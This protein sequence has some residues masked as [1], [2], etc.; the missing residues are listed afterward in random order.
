MH[1]SQNSTSAAILRKR[2]R[3]PRNLRQSYFFARSESCAKVHFGIGVP[4]K[5]GATVTRPLNK[6]SGFFYVPCCAGSM[7]PFLAGRV[8]ASK[9]APVPDSGTPTLHGL[10]PSIGV[11]VGRFT[12]CQ[13]GA[14]M[15]TTLT[16][17]A[18]ARTTSPTTGNP[19]NLPTLPAFTAFSHII[20]DRVAIASNKLKMK[21]VDNSIAR[22]QQ[23]EN[24][25]STALWHVRNGTGPLSIQA[26]TGRAIRAASMLKQACAESTIGGRA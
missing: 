20:R 25:L 16:L 21:P 9:D 3:E 6:D 5:S 11:E 10:S 17:C 22:Q 8:G 13:S 18:S 14:N 24:A 12:T 23:I 1:T 26:A 19:S 15:A 7:A 4:Q 2:N